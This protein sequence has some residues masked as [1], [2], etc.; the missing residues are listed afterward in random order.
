MQHLSAV[1]GFPQMGEPTT[2]SGPLLLAASAL[3]SPG[4]PREQ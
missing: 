1:D 2:S 4:W 3:A